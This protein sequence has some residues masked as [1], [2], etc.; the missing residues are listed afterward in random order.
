MQKYWVSS[1]SADWADEFDVYFFDIYTDTEKNNLNW[2]GQKFPDV[3]LDYCFG[4]NEYWEE[5]DGFKIEVEGQEATKEEVE[6]LCKFGIQG[7]SLKDR[8]SD[9]V[10]SILDERTRN[11][12][13]KEYGSLIH[14]PEEVFQAYDF[15][16]EDY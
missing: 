10:W 9:F 16:L 2:L 5:E 11:K 15:K 8:F 1:F 14:V 13:K 4:T 3:K 12:W 7:E 6:T